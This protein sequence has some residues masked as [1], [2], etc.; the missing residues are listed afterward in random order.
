MGATPQ[1][2]PN[3]SSF[4]DQDC[5][6]LSQF[7]ILSPVLAQDRPSLGR[8]VSGLFFNILI[9][10]VLQKSYS[11]N[12]GY[13]FC[14]HLIFNDIRILRLMLRPLQSFSP[15]LAAFSVSVEHPPQHPRPAP[16]P[17]LLPEP[18][19]QAS[20]SSTRLTARRWTSPT[21]TT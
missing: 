2:R 18:L 17:E 11:W 3:T 15:H 16:S 19:S 13:D 6:S 12:C 7:E 9:I 8:F 14:N 1:T 20:T 5:T 10:N 21:S 4:L